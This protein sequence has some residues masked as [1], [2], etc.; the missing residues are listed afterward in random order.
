MA[1]LTVSDPARVHAVVVGIEHYPRAAGWDLVGACAD[2]VRFARWLR[3]RG[4]PAANI[5]LLLAAAPSSH[6]ALN[7]AADDIDLKPTYVRSRDRIMDCFTPQGPVPEGDVLFVYWGGHGVLDHGDRRLLLCPDA[8]DADRRCIELTNLQ[9]YL[10]GQNVA[11]FPQHVFLVDACARFIEERRTEDQTGPALAAFPAGRR[12]SLTQFTL[13]AAAAGQVA[14]QGTVVAGAGDFSTVVTGWLEEHS[15]ELTPDLDA[16]VGHVKEHFTTAGGKSRSRS[17]TP[18]SLLIQPLGGNAQVFAPPRPSRSEPARAAARADGAGGRGEGGH[19]AGVWAGVGA[20][21]LV[22][23]VAIV[24]MA[25]H[26]PRGGDARAGQAGPAGS[27]GSESPGKETAASPSP[28][29]S[30]LGSGSA[31][32]SAPV[33]AAAAPASQKPAAAPSA[34]I[35][36]Q[37]CGAEHTT[38]IQD[39]LHTVCFVQVGKQVT[40]VGIVRATVPKTVTVNLW[41]VGQ[42]SGSYVFPD[43]GPQTWTIQAGAEPQR[44]AM[45]ITAALTPKAAY[46]VRIATLPAGEKMNA[47]ATP[48]R[49]HSMPFT[50]N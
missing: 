12:E 2:A 6:T 10:T 26:G 8:S 49:G 28:S 33:P 29:P 37:S 14:G 7:E 39:V 47:T 22:A 25:L 3:H 11:R 13:L 19:R 48:I 31:S 45:P 43:K 40:M 21:A 15:P 18:V 42:P 46:E 38:G 44:F 17:Q 24:A 9:E 30:P 34:S 50:A 4:V 41:L 32:P 36:G 1:E 35:S 16:L 23:M 5:M 27:V 20:L